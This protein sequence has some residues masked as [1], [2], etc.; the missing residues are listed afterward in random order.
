MRRLTV[1]A[2]LQK[3]GGAHVRV[4]APA[5]GSVD[6]VV[7]GVRDRLLPMEREADGHFNVVDPDARAGGRYWF[8][9]DGER[10]RPDPAS[11]WQPDGPHEPSAY[12]DPFAFRWTDA[13]RKGVTPVGQVVYELHIG[14]FTPAGTWTAAASQ[15][16]E[17]ARIGITVIEMMPIAEFPG[18]FGW[19]Y[20]GVDLFAPAHI[21]GTPDD[22]RAFVDRAHALGLG[23]IL[24]VVYNHLGPDGNYLAEFSP[25]Y[26]TD[27]YTNDWGRALNFEGPAAAR[28]YFVQNARYWIEEFHFDGLRLDATQDVKDASSRHVI[29]EIIAAARCAAGTVPIYAVA[30]NEPQHTALVRTP[31]SGGYGADALWNDDAHHTAVVALTGRREAYYRDYQGSPQE[32]ISCARFGYL[33]QGQWYSW[34]QKRR[35]TPALDLNPHAF[36][37]YLENHDQVANSAFGRRL[38]QSAAPGRY[39]ALTAWMLLGPATPMLFQGQEFASSRPFLYF[40]DHNPEL[41]ESVRRG[42]IE[43]LAQFPSLTDD[44]VVRKLPAP[45]DVRTFE[46]SK[47]DLTERER[48]HDAYA[49]HCD[50]LKLRREDPVLSRA[51]TYRPEGAVIGPGAVLLRYVDATHGDRLVIVNLECDLDFTP[52]REPLLAPP[53]NARWTLAWSSEAPQ[54]GGQGTPPLDPDGVWI[55]PGSS[56]MFLVASRR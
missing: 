50:L 43:F 2:E 27:K 24:D 6:L 49:F 47:L 21:Y 55:V 36:V 29:A 5:C 19:G 3:R 7:A 48:H 52:A 16:D 44:R 53:F 42:R 17:L 12:V 39:R 20:D 37:T 28:A 40:A 15:L 25:D 34:Q 35:G 31:E 10:L 8:R 32:L 14:T 46:A 23:V 22:L 54:Y 38:H 18:R 51:G 13:N 41:A 11:R 30:E 33:Y 45:G 56:A 1:G 26:F 4:W 9:L